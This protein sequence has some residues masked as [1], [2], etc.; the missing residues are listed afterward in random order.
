MTKASIGLVGAGRIG[1]IHADNVMRHPELSLQ[2]VTDIDAS[3]AQ[4]VA[5]K[6]GAKVATFDEMLQDPTISG[7][8]IASPTD[9]HAEQTEQA[10]RHG[11]AV[12]CEKPV[13]L[14][15]E[16]ID[17]CLSVI[18]DTGVPLLVGFN[19]RFDRHFGELKRRLQA[20]EIGELESI[21]ITSRDPSPPDA[22]YIRSSGGIF[23][24][25]TVHD[26]DMARWLLNEEPALVHAMASNLV[27]DT[28]GAVGDFDTAVVSM[29]TVSGKLCQ[30][31]NSRRSAYGYDQRV[32]VLGSK[33]MLRADNVSEH[34]VT[35]ST[36]SGFSSSRLESFFLERYE[37]S[38]RAEID[39]FADVLG[40]Q[41]IPKV[42][43]VDG[44]A[45][46]ALAE[47]AAESLRIGAEVSVHLQGDAPKLA[48]R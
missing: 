39:H 26:F 29:R 22:D 33:G 10:A 31:S 43:G 44:R 9:A 19:R 34:T 37:S 47:A 40:A 41:A 11:K 15:V 7:V 8:I 48:V 17:R 3:R 5:E 4:A 30:I 13:D 21:H 45:A 23:K 35:S 27:D 36:A 14:S 20:G 32:E 1:E 16:R 18:R 6:S 46:V 25:M 12:L 2:F 42:T 28:I 38:F 24:D